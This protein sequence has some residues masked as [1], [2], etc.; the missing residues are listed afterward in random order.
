ME[1]ARKN[2]PY[3]SELYKDLPENY[4]LS[5]LPRVNKRE[6]MEHWDAWVT[7]RELTLAETERFMEDTDNIGRKLKKKYMVYTTSGST[8]NPLVAVYDDT[9]N[10][11][12]GGIS[13]CRSYARSEDLKAFIR[14]GG[15]SIGV[16]ADGGFYLGNSSIRSHLLAMPWKKR[17]LA[18]SSA[19]YPIANIVRQLNDFQPAMLGGY[20]SNLELL[21][22]EAKEGRLRISPVIIMTG[23]EYLSDDLRKRLSEAFHCYVQTAYA[24]TEGGTGRSSGGDLAVRGVAVPE[25]EQRKIQTYYKEIRV[26][27]M[28]VFQDIKIK[29]CIITV[30][31]S[32]FLAFGIYNVHSLSGVTEGGVLGLTLLLEHWF[33]ISPSI[34]NFVASA[35]CYLMGFRLLGRTF[36]IYSGIAVACFSVSYKIFEQFDPLW[37]QLYDMPLLAA[38]IGAVFVGVGAGVCVRVGGA[39]SGDDALA[40]SISSLTHMKIE[41]VYLISDLV[42]LGLSITYIPLRRIGYSLLT[43][44]LSGQII[45][46][47]R[48]LDPG[49]K[50]NETP[51]G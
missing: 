17:Q 42:V 27:G 21:I 43:V 25:S 13:A 47:I 33:D 32:V 6:L 31:G 18:V 11:I 39:V 29:S 19:L 37:P 38:V 48:R 46:W 1:W 40:M 30:L 41:R 5:D 14:R 22:D 16:F 51:R 36:I 3:Y 2:S 7:D 26:R 20:P 8:G 28:K 10:N 34:T 50:R 9:A 23:G 4:T 45:G 49:E 15:K 44:I 24:C 12:M 35:V